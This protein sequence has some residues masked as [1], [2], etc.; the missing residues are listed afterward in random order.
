MP[1]TRRAMSTA[2]QLGVSSLNKDSS[3]SRWP[4][5]PPSPTN[6]ASAG[7]T[8]NQVVRARPASSV[9]A[10]SVPQWF[11]LPCQA[12][13]QPRTMVSPTHVGG[14]APDA[15]TA[16]VSGFGLGTS[17]ET[18]FVSPCCRKSLWSSI[19]M[20]SASIADSTASVSE[21]ASPS[22]CTKPPTTPGLSSSSA[23]GSWLRWMSFRYACDACG[24]DLREASV[25]KWAE[26]P[27]SIEF[28]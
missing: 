27:G 5:W 28:A 18:D 10:L 1:R 9:H 13:K 23:H 15:P 26:K 12:A 20:S 3:S 25:V 2:T 21:L 19:G 4:R 7:T 8:L 17:N 22:P 14:A 6:I 16:R 11:V 24:V